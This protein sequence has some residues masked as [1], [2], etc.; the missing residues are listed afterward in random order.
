MAEN[1]CDYRY[2]RSKNNQEKRKIENQIYGNK[3]LEGKALTLG[4]PDEISKRLDHR[5][6][7]K[8]KKSKAWY[9]T[10]LYAFESKRNNRVKDVFSRHNLTLRYN[11][12][13][14]HMKFPS[15]TST[16]IS[17]SSDD[18]CYSSDDDNDMIFSEHFDV[19][20]DTYN[21]YH[22]NNNND[23]SDNNNNNNNNNNIENISSSDIYDNNNINMNS[24]V[25]SSTTTTTTITTNDASNNNHNK[26]S[27][28]S[29]NN[30][31]FINI[32]PEP[33]LTSSKYKC[34]FPGCNGYGNV[35]LEKYIH[36]T[37]E[38]CP[39]YDI[40]LKSKNTASIRYQQAIDQMIRLK[41]MEEEKRLKMLRKMKLKDSYATK[42]LIR[43][44]RYM[45]I[46]TAVVVVVKAMN[47][48]TI[49]TWVIITIG[50]IHFQELQGIIILIQ[51]K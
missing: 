6:L 37:M 8:Y 12:P 44:K 34:I 31:N 47:R 40:F 4:I 14:L 39:M 17:D 20:N 30:K 29:Y 28:H 45:V 21:S 18:N 15:K 11:H 16:Y 32:S 23:N 10:D 35:D 5:G 41:G 46:P 51:I 43:E 38:E 24:D 9:D 2:R 48:V 36:T 3:K 49:V 27:K 13:A 22:N 33:V 1:V 25:S 50:N 26:N 7:S 19:N 42:L